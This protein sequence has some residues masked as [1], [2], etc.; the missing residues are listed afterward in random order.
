MP[1]RLITVDLRYEHDVVL[2]RQRARQISSLLGF[3]VLDQTRIATAVSEL[4]RNV[5]AH[6]TSGKVEFLIERSGN[7]SLV[8]RVLD[9]G[10]GISDLKAVLDGQ[11]SYGVGGG[12]GIVAAKRLM[13]EFSIGS[14]SDEGTVIQL[15]KILPKMILDRI[16][17]RISNVIEELARRSPQNP[18]E[19][20]QN[21][22]QE[23]LS[24]MD[25]LRARQEEL[26]RLNQELAET[27]RGVVALYSELDDN[28]GE[29]QRASELKT[30]FLSNMSHEFRTPLASIIS[31]A[32]IL[33]CRLDGDLTSEQEKQVKFIKT[34]AESLHGVVNDLLDIAKI[35]AGKMDVLPSAFHVSDLFTTLKR[36]FQPL[37]RPAEVELVFASSDGIPMLYTDE[38]KLLQILRNFVS[39]ALKFTERGHVRV[40]ASA[41]GAK[42]VA[43]AV[44][45]TGIGIAPEHIELIFAEFSQI[46]GNYQSTKH[47]TGLGL[48]L[49][50]KLAQALGGHI[51]VESQLGVGSTFSATIPLVYSGPNDVDRR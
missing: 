2:T 37:A 39:N 8:I 32:D 20:I 14:N 13:D 6:A 36:T 41:V 38:V 7:P 5:I 28:A 31:L 21:Q 42:E 12:A 50:R 27:N 4:A 11:S 3:D 35:E 15:G 19:E 1:I 24:L 48:S 46:R 26:Q 45:D 33:L 44:S 9:N 17:E 51:N 40:S 18:F 34:S 22:N 29:L 23:L 43:F 25:D 10:P 47:G 30:R 49:S 16:P